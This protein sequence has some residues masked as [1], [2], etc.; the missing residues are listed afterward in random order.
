MAVAHGLHEAFNT[1]PQGGEVVVF[2][3]GSQLTIPHRKLKD[4]SAIF[5]IQPLTQGSH[6]SRAHCAIR[7]AIATLWRAITR[8]GTA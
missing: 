8:W 4:R 5:A 3:H 7:N 1:K 2:A 6:A